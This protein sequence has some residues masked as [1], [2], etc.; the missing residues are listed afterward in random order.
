VKELR[1]RRGAA[2]SEAECDGLDM[3]MGEEMKSG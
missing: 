2:L 3:R 1:Q